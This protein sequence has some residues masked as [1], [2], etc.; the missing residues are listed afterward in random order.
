MA[1]FEAN[2][3][4]ILYYIHIRLCVTAPIFAHHLQSIF[5]EFVVIQSSVI[6]VYYSLI[7]NALMEIPDVACYF[8]A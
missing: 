3:I 8:K 1:T 7:L 5:S 2:V 4:T 6:N